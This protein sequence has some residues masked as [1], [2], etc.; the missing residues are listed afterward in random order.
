M[1]R[2]SKR[3]FHVCCFSILIGASG[4]AMAQKETTP[5]NIGN[6]IL[7]KFQI[8][9]S[10]G[11]AVDGKCF[12]AI[13]NTRISKCTKNSGE[14]ISVWQAD[15]KKKA[16]IHFKHL[17]SGTVVAGKLYCAHSRFPISPNDCTVGIFNVKGDA[18][19]H[20]KTIKMPKKHGSL[21]W[22]DQRGDGSWWMCYAVYGKGKN[23]TTKLVKYRYDDGVFTEDRTWF[24]PA[25]V[26]SRWGIIK[27]KHVPLTLPP[28]KKG[29][30]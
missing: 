24:F 28:S 9:V 27:N 2:T 25:E 6:V 21:T 1:S 19:E 23:N 12:Y 8:K 13:S 20:K 5:P 22:I 17:N 18:L 10:Q 14:E 11:V 26:I 7:K 4:I 3:I 30:P 15:L 16:E 29:Q